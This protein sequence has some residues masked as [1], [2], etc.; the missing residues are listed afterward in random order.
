[1]FCQSRCGCVLLEVLLLHR[2]VSSVRAV[3]AAVADEAGFAR[4]VAHQVVA[5]PFGGQPEMRSMNGG[6]VNELTRYAG[7]SCCYRRVIA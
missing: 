3:L 7:E 6:N 4:R 2:P 1:M 5:E